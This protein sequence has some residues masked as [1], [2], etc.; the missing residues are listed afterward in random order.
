MTPGEVRREGCVRCRMRHHPVEAIGAVF[1][2]QMSAGAGD[3]VVI[4]VCPRAK[5]AYQDVVWRRGEIIPH[6]LR[7]L[8]A[9]D[10][11]TGIFIC[12][13]CRRIDDT[14]I[15]LDA[16]FPLPRQNDSVRGEHGFAQRPPY[17]HT[18]Y[19]KGAKY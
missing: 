9:E 3:D 6:L 4:H 16:Q 14:A 12:D 2:H 19:L 7:Q 8:L 5:T 18:H 13:T 11:M 1:S 15:R 17:S 10:Q